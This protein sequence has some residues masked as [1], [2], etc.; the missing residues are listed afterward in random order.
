VSVIMYFLLLGHRS[1][2]EAT[3]A[4][5]CGQRL[6]VRA[7]LLQGIVGDAALGQH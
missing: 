3:Q 7:A 2:I 4:G 5:P 1:G 6:L